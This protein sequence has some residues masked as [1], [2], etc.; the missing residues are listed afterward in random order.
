MKTKTVKIF[1]NIG[2]FF[3]TAFYI[4][5]LIVCL[6]YIVWTWIVEAEKRSRRRR[7]Q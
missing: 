3:Y 7:H 6:P 2:L 4:I 5:W 1:I